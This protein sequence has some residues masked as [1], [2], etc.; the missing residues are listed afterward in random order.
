MNIKNSLKTFLGYLKNHY[1]RQKFAIGSFLIVI[2]IGFL[3]M[4]ALTSADQLINWVPDNASFYLHLKTDQAQPVWQKIKHLE[5]FT[6]YPHTLEEIIPPETE[7]F[8]IFLSDETYGIILSGQKP[9]PGT[10]NL[11]VA[12]L[13]NGVFLIS[14]KPLSLKKNKVISIAAKKGF[15]PEPL[16]SA[17]Y[18]FMNKPEI[19]QSSAVPA[20]PINI[21]T[22]QAWS[23]QIKDNQIFWQN[24]A[25]SQTRQATEL[26]SRYLPQNTV[27][28][29]HGN[30]WQS[31]ADASLDSITDQNSPIFTASQKYHQNISQNSLPESSF[32]PLFSNPFDLFIINQSKIPTFA[33]KLKKIPENNPIWLYNFEQ[34]WLKQER[35]KLPQYTTI[36]LPDGSRAVE[37]TSSEMLN[38]QD[39]NITGKNIR[40]LKGANDEFLIGYYSD[41]DSIIIS[42]NYANLVDFIYNSD[43]T[44]WLD[45]EK[46]S[47]NC[48][49]NQSD[50]ALYYASAENLS[51][52]SQIFN[53][54]GPYLVDNN[55]NICHI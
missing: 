13:E 37:M 39:Q 31:A 22:A 1:P 28:W 43:Q 34:Y 15:K 33:L 21:A 44:S 51:K 12:T 11:I 25:P 45:L 30:D 10:D 24:Q 54:I 36:L 4:R 50:L 49:F 35:Q 14:E 47:Q 41:Q 46:Y 8:S 32:Q 17:G 42:N 38:W 40:W 3:S 27:F 5:P 52:I 20:W 26:R 48:N 2:L 18:L 53:I 29:T 19:P 7:E 55:N 9:P 16:N 23:L 6:E